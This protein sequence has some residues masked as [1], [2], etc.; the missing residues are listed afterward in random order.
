MHISITAERPDTT[1]AIAL[2]DELQTYLE[3]F[4]A[5]EHRHGYSVQQ[6][7]DAGVDFYVLRVDGAAAGCIG[8]LC[9]AEYAEIKRMYI[10]PAFRRHKLGVTLL[11]H[12]QCVAQARAIPL[13]RL[14]TGI[15]QPE[16]NARY[17]SFGFRLIP[18]FGPYHDDG[19]SLC[20]EKAVPPTSST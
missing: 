9:L 11:E 16:A 10:R 8:V 18:A 3:S 17:E 19:V 14:E 5:P 6:L 2:I 1:D 13:L 20:Y 4:Y 12:V 15:H 7:I